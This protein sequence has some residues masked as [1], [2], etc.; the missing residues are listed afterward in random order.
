MHKNW[1]KRL[2]YTLKDTQT[3][4]LSTATGMAAM[5]MTAMIGDMSYD[6]QGTF[7]PIMVLFGTTLTCFGGFIGYA[8]WG[9]IHEFDEQIQKDEVEAG[10]LK[11]IEEKKREEEKQNAKK[12]QL[13]HLLELLKESVPL[14]EEMRNRIGETAKLIRNIVETETI[15]IEEEH[16]L[17]YT[18]PR[19]MTD[20]IRL[21]RKLDENRK[22]S[23]GQ[24]VLSYV[25]HVQEELQEK[26]VE[27]YQRETV[28]Q[29]DKKL[30][31][32]KQRLSIKE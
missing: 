24:E 11:K 6:Y 3:Y 25:E 22:R 8:L 32:S 26:F 19:D 15:A 9:N 20:M 1:R 4:A 18:L 5:G 27:R 28:H 16:Y 2:A 29:L 7:I 21:Y 17:T 13:E 31:V 12:E 23:K 30:L 14:D 10:V